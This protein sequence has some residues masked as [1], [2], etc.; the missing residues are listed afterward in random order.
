MCW[1]KPVDFYLAKNIFSTKLFQHNRNIQAT[2][3]QRKSFLKQSN[4]TVRFFN[5]L[6][7]LIDI[8][9]TDELEYF[10][11]RL[12][13]DSFFFWFFYMSFGACHG[14]VSVYYWRVWGRLSLHVKHYGPER[15]S[16]PLQSGSRLGIKLDS[17]LAW[18]FIGLK[19]KDL[20]WESSKLSRKS[21]T[22]VSSWKT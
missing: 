16:R 18:N 13:I 14:I 19:F 1:P 17:V 10:R 7:I 22:R 5:Q 2:T 4:N 11:K 21:V 3:E 15:K 20:I 8:Q 9:C 12:K 6:R